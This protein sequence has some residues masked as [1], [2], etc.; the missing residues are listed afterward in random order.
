[1][2]WGLLARLQWTSL[3]TLLPRRAGPRAIR[4]LGAFT[5]LEAYRST[6]ARERGEAW[7]DLWLKHPVPDLLQAGIN[8][9]E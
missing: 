5:C 7:L 9:A 4:T 2:P 1:M 8:S 3:F 6:C